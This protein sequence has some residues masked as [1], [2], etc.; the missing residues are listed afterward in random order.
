MTTDLMVLGYLT[1]GHNP[2]LIEASLMSRNKES[3]ATKIPWLTLSITLIL[4][5]LLLNLDLEGKSLWADEL[6]TAK[7]ALLSPQKVIR[8]TAADVHPPLYFLLLSLWASCAGHSDFAL[9]WLSAATGWLSV[10]VLYRLGRAW[11]GPTVG[12]LSAA[13]WGLSPLLILYGRMA[14]YYSLAALLGLLSTYALWCSLKQGKWN[15]WVAYVVFSSAALYT[16]YLTGLLLLIQGWFA[17]HLKGRSGVLHWLVSMLLVS[18]SLLPWS[19]VI[20][21]QSV[22]TGS[23]VAD[24]TYSVTGIAMKI[25]YSAYALALGES[26]FP[27]HPLAVAGG[28]AA[29]TLLFLG[30]AW[31]REQS[32]CPPLLGLLLFPFVGMIV[33]TT[34]VSPRT[35]FVSMPART[36]F[37]APYFFLIL[38]GGFVKHGLRLLII[39]AATL[40]AAW[41]LSLVNYYH[42]QQF[43]NPIYLTPAREIVCQ[44]LDQL[45]PGDAIFSPED[46]GFYYYYE[47]SGAQAPH[48]RDSAQAVIH[49]E[50]GEVKRVWLITLGRDQTRRSAP[51]AVQEWLQTHCRMTKSWNYVPQDPTY[52]AIKSYLLSRPAYEYRA[53]LFLYVREEQ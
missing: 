24:L 21:S 52:R 34:L 40:T 23:G 49:F 20:A 13:L 39:L 46:S 43:L 17:L 33:V 18:L 9:R 32:L 26:L 45:Q 53:G 14:R 29:L 6:F 41:S 51:T 48:F 1:S 7:C 12:W 27:W 22:R 31:W 47:Q 15:Y 38:G 44:V 8:H 2:Y 4:S 28:A 35:P 16:F 37:A 10:A 3:Q 50:S 11:A 5:W 30:I 25:A 19:G 42:N 36:F